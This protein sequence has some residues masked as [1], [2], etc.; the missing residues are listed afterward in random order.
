[1]T[2]ISMLCPSRG[3]PRAAKELLENFRK[4]ILGEQQLLF[5]CD[6]DD[7]SVDDYPPRE[8][9]LAARMG[10]VQT[11]NHW[12]KD[13]TSRYVGF[14]GDDSRFATHGWDRIT[15]DAL[16]AIGG[17]IAWFD[18]TTSANPWASTVVMDTR[19]VK[20]LGYMIPPTLQRGWFDVLWMNLAEVSMRAVPLRE[21]Q[22][23]HDNHDSKVAP[24][25]IEAD[26]MA[27]EFWK[28]D[29][30][31]ND[32]AKI[33]AALGPPPSQRIAIPTSMFE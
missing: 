10:P 1:M 22:V 16:D 15:T 2:D 33:R 18:D 28:R 7:N 32:V 31:L 29:Q 19:I 26:E 21:V 6:F 30:M 5:L 23:P 27:Y 4:T 11:L 24:I 13:I 3:R 9:L 25:V 14:M 12:A 17:G 20:A 8:T